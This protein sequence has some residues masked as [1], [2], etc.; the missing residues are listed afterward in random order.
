MKDD[1]PPLQLDG[2]PYAVLN[3]EEVPQW[4]GIYGKEQNNSH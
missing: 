1:L 2:F 3:G 4:K